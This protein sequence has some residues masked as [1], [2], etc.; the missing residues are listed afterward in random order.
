MVSVTCKL[1]FQKGKLWGGRFTG[2]TDP[3]MEQFNASIGF[4]KRM[5]KADIQGSQAYVKALQKV[6]IV[7]EEEMNL[8]LDGLKKVFNSVNRIDCTGRGRDV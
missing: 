6:D 1:S 7:T 8:I 3:I 2:E 4:D 5:W